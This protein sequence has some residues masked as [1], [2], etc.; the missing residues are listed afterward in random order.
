MKRCL[1]K[2]PD[3]QRSVRSK[4]SSVLPVEDYSS[5]VRTEVLCC[6]VS[7]SKK[8]CLTTH[9]LSQGKFREA[10]FEF[11]ASGGTTWCQLL[12][13]DATAL[14]TVHTIFMLGIFTSSQPSP[15]ECR[16]ETLPE[17]LRRSIEEVRTIKEQY[18]L[19]CVRSAMVNSL[20]TAL[21]S[22]CPALYAKAVHLILTRPV[23]P[24]LDELLPITDLPS[25]NLRSGVYIQLRNCTNPA[26]STLALM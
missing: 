12:N 7:S 5:L 3:Q 23:L 18:K 8:R 14:K 21:S 15:S 13:N 10:M 24:P 2:V 25:P 11:T 26:Y 1:S 17:T 4:K 22:A 16:I 20:K 9:P 6:Y 19:L